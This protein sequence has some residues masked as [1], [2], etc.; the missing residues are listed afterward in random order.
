MHIERLTRLRERRF[1]TKVRGGKDTK[2]VEGISSGDGRWNVSADFTHRK[3]LSVDVDVRLSVLGAVA[4]LRECWCWVAPA[5]CMTAEIDRTGD[6]ITSTVH[7]RID[8]LVNVGKDVEDVIQ[9]AFARVGWT[10]N[11]DIGQVRGK[12]FVSD[13]VVE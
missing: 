6:R 7:S 12:A 9:V 8:N 11:V 10:M 5:V 3:C 4:R 2:I 13:D 1:E